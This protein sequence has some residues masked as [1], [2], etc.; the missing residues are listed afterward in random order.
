MA[1]FFDKFTYR[2]A[3]Y[4]SPSSSSVADDMIF[5]LIC[6]MVSMMPFFVGVTVSFDKKKWPPAWLRAFVLFRYP[7]LLCVASI[8]WVH[9]YVRAA[10]SCVET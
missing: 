8:I 9:E 3:I 2:E 5:C 10:S 4:R 6:A 1:K 7:V